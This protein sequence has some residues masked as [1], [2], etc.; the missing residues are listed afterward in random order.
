MTPVPASDLP[1]NLVPASDLPS[2]G[3]SPTAP[4]AQSVESTPLGPK[5]VPGDVPQPAR[6]PGPSAMDLILGVPEALAGIGQGTLAQLAGRA[7]ALFNGPAG[8]KVAS[9]MSPEVSE[10][11]KAVLD[12][13]DSWLQKSKL[14]G[15]GPMVMPEGQAA[16]VAATGKAALP[17]AEAAIKQG[18]R[19]TPEE[20]GAGAVG[21][22][23]AS[24]AGEPK[25]AKLVS[26]KNEPLLNA[27]IAGD[28]GLPADTPMT[29]DSLA[30]VRA[31]AGKAYE[32]VRGVGQVQTDAAFNQALDKVQA[33]Y[34]GAAKSF[35]K[36]AKED[37][38]KMVDGLR[39]DAFDSGAAIDQIRIL[40]QDADKAFRQG[41]SGFGKANRAAAQALEDQIDRHLSD[42]MTSGD[43]VNNFRQARERIAKS[44]TAEKA[45]VGETGNINSQVYAQEL[46][47]GKPLTGGAKEV[48]QFASSFPRSAQKPVNTSSA[49]SWGDVLISEL[50]KDWRLLFAR[51]AAR[52]L[53]SSG[54]Y[55]K[56]QTAQPSASV[57]VPSPQSLQA[58][59]VA[60]MLPQRQQ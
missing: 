18:L 2:M 45:L 21:R 50:G 16:R 53:L 11:G 30:Q 40:R 54:A 57:P 48:G 46:A 51:P 38:K 32:A 43:V 59:G 34:E 39:V 19:I 28:L 15:M 37:V 60:P 24:L 52:S 5:D 29:R 20:A 25:L 12:K 7:T 22:T 3:N 36:L 26:K 1:A 23:A 4:N 56:M 42:G 31:E 41:D 35:P 33:L 47:K 14:E 17:E 44:Y 8:Q 58:L 6:Q 9:A 27:Y 49:G 55:N 13:I 10:R